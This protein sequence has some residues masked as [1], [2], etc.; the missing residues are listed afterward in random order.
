MPL[1]FDP[2]PL[3][4]QG[5]ETNKDH[6]NKHTRISS[7]QDSD[8]T[9]SHRQ[10]LFPTTPS[11]A[12]GISLSHQSSRAHTAY[13]CSRST[14]HAY[15]DNLVRQ[16]FRHANHQRHSAFLSLTLF[17]HGPRRS[18]HERLCVLHLL[19]LYSPTQKGVPLIDSLRP[20][21]S[22]GQHRWSSSL[23]FRRHVRHSLSCQQIC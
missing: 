13:P 10:T 21:P 22:Q 6:Q 5:P 19:I 18:E 2:A 23:R 1:K 14:S 12:V 8:I 4:W 16:P 20:L 11:T 9:C 3:H 7:A 15:P 17:S